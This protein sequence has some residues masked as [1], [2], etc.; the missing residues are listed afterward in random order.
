MKIHPRTRVTCRMSGASLLLESGCVHGLSRSRK[1]VFLVK[2]RSFQN[3]ACLRGS[4]ES[5]LRVLS[6]QKNKAYQ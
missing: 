3:G 5:E 2:Q 6:M 1:E 4:K